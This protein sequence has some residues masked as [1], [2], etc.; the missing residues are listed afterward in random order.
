[1]LCCVVFVEMHD[2]FETEV[3]SIEY[4]MFCVVSLGAL[5]IVNSI[6]Y[7]DSV[8][9]TDA[10]MS[11]YEEE[12]LYQAHLH[13]API[14]YFLRKLTPTTTIKMHEEIK[15]TS[16]IHGKMYAKLLRRERKM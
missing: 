13:Y 2:L 9:S 11:G 1:M 3:V 5:M 14:S 8:L 6:M 7:S 12:L 10:Q 16:S 15:T 4:L